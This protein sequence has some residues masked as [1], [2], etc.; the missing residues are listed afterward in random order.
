VLLVRAFLSKVAS[1]CQSNATTSRGCKVPAAEGFKAT[2]V[3]HEVFEDNQ[4]V[5]G[6]QNLQKKAKRV[7]TRSS[8]TRGCATGPGLFK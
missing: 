7:V 2:A 1:A 4:G 8:Y 5:L 6:E 3:Y